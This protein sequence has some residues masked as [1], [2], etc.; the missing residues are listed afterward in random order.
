MN[1]PPASNEGLN[2]W[3]QLS[4]RASKIIAWL[5][6]IAG[7]QSWLLLGHGDYGH[8]DELRWVLAAAVLALIPPV[9]RGVN[10]WWEFSRAPSPRA[11]LF[12]FIAI[13]VATPL[14]IHASER[15]QKIAIHPYFHDE[16]SYLIQM[17]MLARGHLWMASHPCAAS[18]DSF[19]LITHPVYASMYFPGTAMM[20][21]PVIWLHLP[22]VVATLAAG[23]LCAGL[24]Y[25]VLTE[26]LDGA[27]ALIAVLVLL[28]MGI[29]RLGAI[30]LLSQI[31]VLLLGLLMTFA[32]LQWRERREW[33][34]MALL[35]AAAGWAAITRPADALC[36]AL[37]IGTAIAI[38]LRRQ[39]P[40]VWAKNAVIALVAAAPF[41]TVQS[42]FDYG[43]TGHVLLTPFEYY[44]DQNSPGARYG[45]RAL[46]TEALP[47]SML[48]QKRIFFENRILPDLEQHQI[49]RFPALLLDR[50]AFAFDNL[51][52]E[53]MFWLIFPLAVAG[54]FDLRRWAV[55]GVIP[56]FLL[57][58]TAYA[59]FPLPTYL[60]TLSPAMALMPVLPIQFLCDVFP[61]RKPLVRTLL[62]LSILFLVIASM[63]QFDRLVHDQYFE[64]HEGEAIN[65]TLAKEV[66]PPAVVLFH[67]NLNA[68]M[69]GKLVTNNAD[70]EPVYNS[71]VAWPDDAP[72]IRAHD[73]NARV[74]AIGTKNDRN[75]PLYGY[76]AKSGPSRVFYL[77]DRLDGTGKLT[78]LGTA[79]ELTSLTASFADHSQQSK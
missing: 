63:P 49:S 45:F 56:I 76:Y 9:R 17:Q 31:P 10:L 40:R 7:V 4:P 5:L 78:R 15:Y 37:A 14:F 16:S 51:I 3:L 74:T 1:P 24:F 42:I 46:P 61:R 60:V 55:W 25:L 62:G 2:A 64:M 79:S 26:M 12:I 38:D 32:W 6:M 58:Y 65:S 23:G 29:F 13:T 67:F 50:C 72:I 21:V 39:R 66:S 57:L 28:S 18:F 44:T 27:M 54:M 36:F 68:Q 34:W 75:R 11:R 20:Y 41:L 73:L 19:Y 30:M 48:P 35:G 69:E 70:E 53:P 22:W 71:D 8:R 33:A 43:V 52:I 77:Y 47:V 59:F